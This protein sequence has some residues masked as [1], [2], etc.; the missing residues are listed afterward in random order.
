MG[1]HKAQTC[2]LSPQFGGIFLKFL[3][4]LLGI[5]PTFLGLYFPV[6]KVSVA[7]TG[8]LGPGFQACRALS[9]LI[10]IMSKSVTQTCRALSDLRLVTSRSVTW[11]CACSQTWLFQTWLFAIFQKRR[12]FALRALFAFSCV[13]AFAFFVFNCTFCVHLSVFAPDHV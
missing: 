12:S 13:L 7:D 4:A 6:A 1:L 2:I 9:S 3:Y 8:V 11:M 10:S 5:H